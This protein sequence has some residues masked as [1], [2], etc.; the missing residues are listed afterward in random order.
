MS[1][2][3]IW[4]YLIPLGS[5]T[6]NNPVNRQERGPSKT[7]LFK[8]PTE[9]VMH[10]WS[11]RDQCSLGFLFQ[12]FT[13]VFRQYLHLKL[14]D[15]YNPWAILC[16]LWNAKF[17]KIYSFYLKSINHIHVHTH[18]IGHFERML[19]PHFTFANF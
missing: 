7:L 15:S 2:S 16:I 9:A 1:I 14:G 4:K 13:G 12:N 6:I 5:Q 8:F 3:P 18:G 19:P 10:S 17:L 11:N